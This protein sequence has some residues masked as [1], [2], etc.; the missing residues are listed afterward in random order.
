MSAW[1]IVNANS[2]GRIVN[3]V[4]WLSAGSIFIWWNT[5]TKSRTEKYFALPN[6]FN[7]ST[8]FD[9]GYASPMVSLLKAR[10]SK[11]NLLFL[12]IIR[13]RTYGH[14]FLQLWRSPKIGGWLDRLVRHRVL[15]SWDCPVVRKTGQSDRKWR[16]L[17]WL[18]FIHLSFKTN[19]F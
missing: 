19:Q 8:I 17:L 14:T 16:Q 10:K 15:P 13:T 6:W 4:L 11:T 1:W 2:D 7:I 18:R 3:A 9:S 12:K 5:D